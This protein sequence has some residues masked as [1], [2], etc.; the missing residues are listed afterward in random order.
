LL[1]EMRSERAIGADAIL[2]QAQIGRQTMKSEI[3]VIKSAALLRRVVER[4]RLDEDSEF[5]AGS[6]AATIDRL[7]NALAVAAPRNSPVIKISVTSANSAKAARLANA[8]ADAFLV[9]KLDTR[10]EAARRASAWLADRLVALRRQSR[11]SEEALMRFRAATGSSAN[12]DGANIEPEQR[13]RLARRA[14]GAR[15]EAAE[16]EA[17]L[18][19]LRRIE[20]HGGNA[21]D[22]PGV[23]GAIAELRMRAAQL[24][25]QEA[26]LRARYNRTHPAVVALRAQVADVDRAIEAEIRRLSAGVR[27]DVALAA[28]SR[29]AAETTLRE[30]SSADDRGKSEAITR[31]ELER[32]AAA[33]RK[34]LDDMLRRARMVQEQSRFDPREAR[35]ISPAL[36]PSAPSWPDN[37][38]TMLMALAL[39][40]LAGLGV[41][42]LSELTDTGFTTLAQIEATLTLPLLA[43]ILETR[44]RG[45][46]PI[47][48]DQ[49][50]ARP[51]SR[52]SEAL[53]ALRSAIEMSDV[54]DPPKLIQFAATAPGEGTTTIAAALTASAAQSGLRTLLVDADL[55]NRALSRIFSAGDKP[56]LVDLLIGSAGPSETIF[57]DEARGTWVLPAGGEIQNSADL[58]A[59]EKMRALLD[60]LRRRFDLVIVDTPPIGPI[61]DP[62]IVAR[63]VDKTVVV[64][65]WAATPR[66][67][68]AH[69]IERLPDRGK[70]AGVVFNRVIEAKARKY[71]RYAY[72]RYHGGGAFE[73]YHVE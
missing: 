22:L 42:Y 28:G 59:S 21:A 11:E 38:R 34:L 24:S 3:A 14:A 25:R 36:A 13:A 72:S 27:N 49:M 58:L 43:S 65:R 1:I 53:R 2:T 9:D 73:S 64:I 51:L 20:D 16:R 52:A 19:L 48:A 41:A 37:G 5:G 47:L 10:L 23:G 70:I 18:D 33:D 35:I 6:T 29:E 71:G 61:V 32:A 55:R 69:A 54:D 39:G 56:G 66:E 45:V 63:L 26:E 31:N 4:E 68:V 12:A 67:R 46:A 62:I 15:A 44:A 7:K 50:R 17:R 40:L 30:I 60:A 8:V 57:F